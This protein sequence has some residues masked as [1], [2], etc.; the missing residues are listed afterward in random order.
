MC[1]I[2]YYI[3]DN[4]SKFDMKCVTPFK[5]THTNEYNN[6]NQAS[7]IALLL[8]YLSYKN[9]KLTNGKKIKA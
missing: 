8:G 7:L 1:L 3:F 4:I 2:L 9:P 5:E 6:Q